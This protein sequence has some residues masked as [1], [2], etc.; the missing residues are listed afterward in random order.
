MK[1]GAFISGAPFFLS[2]TLCKRQEYDKS[3]ELF[4]GILLRCHLHPG[5]TRALP[6]Q[7]IFP[8]GSASIGM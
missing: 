1:N 5:S 2:E 3:F 7:I 4:F 8:L 6:N